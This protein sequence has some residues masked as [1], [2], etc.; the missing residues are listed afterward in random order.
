MLEMWLIAR[1]KITNNKSIIKLFIIT[2]SLVDWNKD[3][4]YAFLEGKNLPVS[5][6]ILG[7]KVQ[8]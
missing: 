7:K 1:D 3:D 6:I 8:K 5:T 4:K 2:I